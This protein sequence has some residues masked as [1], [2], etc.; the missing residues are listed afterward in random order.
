M[1]EKSLLFVFEKLVGGCLLFIN[2]FQYWTL[3]NTFWKWKLKLKKSITFPMNFM[4]FIFFILESFKKIKNVTNHF[5]ESKICH[6]LSSNTI[7]IFTLH[8]IKLYKSLLP[9]FGVLPRQSLFNI[10]S[11]LLNIE[12]WTLHKLELEHWGTYLFGWI[13]NMIL[14]GLES[15]RQVHTFR[16][17]CWHPQNCK[18][19]YICKC[20]V[21][22]HVIYLFF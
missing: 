11:M 8:G 5:N 9:P 17:Y 10:F 12:Y 19:K 1:I 22:I 7:L 14:L 16:S 3:L 4:H 21:G 18:F 6:D 13:S 2:G 20:W 15:Q